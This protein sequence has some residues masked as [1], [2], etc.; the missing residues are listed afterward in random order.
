[1]IPIIL[2]FSIKIEFGKLSKKFMGIT[3]STERYAIV[4]TYRA[5]QYGFPTL[6]FFDYDTNEWLTVL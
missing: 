6:G 2:P 4:Y 3:I 5:K 1:M